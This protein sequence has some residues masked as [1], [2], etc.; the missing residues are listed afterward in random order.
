MARPT[1]EVIEANVRRIP[2]RRGRS[3]ESLAKEAGLSTDQLLALFSGEFDP[4]VDVLDRIADALDTA[5]WLL[6]RSRD[7]QDQLTRFGTRAREAGIRSVFAHRQS[8]ASRGNDP[9]PDLWAGV[10]QWAIDRLGFSEGGPGYTIDQG[11]P[12]PDEWRT[13]ARS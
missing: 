12:I 4:P 1:H 5:T 11:N 10:G 2:A 7:R 3:I 9:G 6:V 13:S 8:S